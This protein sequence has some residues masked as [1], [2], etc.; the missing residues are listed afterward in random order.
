MRLTGMLWLWLWF[1]PL[2]LSAGAARL[3]VITLDSQVLKNNPLHDPS[4]RL[5][6]IFLPAQATNGAR[7]PV[8]YYL[9]GY[10][11]SSDD[12]SAIPTSG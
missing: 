6:P 2:I 4:S 8:V 7:L 9:P 5:V 1:A 10:G 3:E 11:S 12:S